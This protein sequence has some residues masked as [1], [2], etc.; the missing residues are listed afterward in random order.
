VYRV[1][2]LYEKAAVMIE[3]NVLIF[4]QSFGPESL[5]VSMCLSQLGEI[6]QCT[7]QYGHPPSLCSLPTPLRARLRLRCSCIGGRV[8]R[9][10]EAIKLYRYA[11]R[12][13]QKFFGPIHPKI[14]S[15]Y[16]MVRAVSASSCT[17]IAAQVTT[18]HTCTAGRDVCGLGPVRRERAV[19]APRHCHCGDLRDGDRVRRTLAPTLPRRPRWHRPCADA[20]PPPPLPLPGHVVQYGLVVADYYYSLYMVCLVWQKYGD[21]RR[22][23]RW[24]A[25]IL[26]TM[27]EDTEEEQLR[28]HLAILRSALH[29]PCL[30]RMPLVLTRDGS[31]VGAGHTQRR[32][33]QAAQNE[34]RAGACFGYS[35]H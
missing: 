19:P 27:E 26:E 15:I 29:C 32:A 6:R 21:A 11:L 3:Q 25:S 34:R 22:Y 5:D 4:S 35:C 14:A 9:W 8:C 7:Q 18:T 30:S 17:C 24:A 12:L 20:V 10:D 31:M 16:F 1:V 2:G 23:L 28:P 33:G 13:A